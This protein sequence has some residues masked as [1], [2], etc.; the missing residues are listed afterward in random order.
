VF[1]AVLRDFF[2]ATF[3]ASLTG[4]DF[5]AA[6]FFAT[7]SAAFAAA[8]A[9]LFSAVAFFVAHRVFKAATTLRRKDLL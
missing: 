4:A 7:T 3:F 8:L 6:A 1:T 9:A 2:A 5:F